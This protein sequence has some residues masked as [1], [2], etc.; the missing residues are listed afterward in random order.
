MTAGGTRMRFPICV[1]VAASLVVVDAVPVLGNWDPLAPGV[2]HAHVHGAQAATI[3]DDELRRLASR[4][5][6]DFSNADAL[7]AF[8]FA[9]GRAT[10]PKLQPRML[11]T[12]GCAS[13]TASS[14]PCVPRRGAREL[15]EGAAEG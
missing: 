4:A 12:H 7:K 15:L 2:Y 3:G 8:A 1:V 11:V 10:N 6:D 14:G 9:L 5:V 13:R